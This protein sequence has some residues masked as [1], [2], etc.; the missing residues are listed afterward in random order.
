MLERTSLRAGVAML[1]A[2]IAAF[3]FIPVNLVFLY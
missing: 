2:L 3:L 1:L